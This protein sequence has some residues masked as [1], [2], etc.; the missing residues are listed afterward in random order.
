PHAVQRQSIDDVGHR[1]SAIAF[2]DPK[3]MQI[4]HNSAIG[5]LSDRSEELTVRQ[6]FSTRLQIVDARLKRKWNWQLPGKPPDIGGSRASAGTSLSW[7]KQEP[8]LLNRPP[9][10][11]SIEAQM[12]TRPRCTKFVYC[13]GKQSDMVAAIAK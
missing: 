7:W 13:L 8:N 4:Q 6:F 11:Y 3:V 12:L 2:V 9:V 1:L 10:L 5:C